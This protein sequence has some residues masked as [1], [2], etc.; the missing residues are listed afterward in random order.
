MERP[1]P[2]RGDTLATMFRTLLF[3]A[4]LS[5]AT[6]V[7]AQQPWPTRSV[8]LVIPNSSGA[9]PDL[10]AR[11]MAE[12]MARN[13]GQPWL[14]DNRPG[15]EEL[16]AAEAV[17]S[18]PPDGYTLALVSQSFVAVN[19][20]TLKSMPMDPARAF[21]AVAV[22]IDTTPIALGVSAALPARN[23]AELMA[24]A[25]AQPGK[26]SYG[27]TVP[28]LAMTGEWL[29]HRAG[30]EWTQIMYKSNAQQVGDTITGTVPVVFS[31]LVGLAPFAKA[32]KLRILAVTSPNR[33]EGF[34]DVPSVMET[35]PDVNVGGGLVLLA[36]AGTRADIVQRLNRETDT[37]VRS[38]GFAKRVAEFGW[39]NRGGARTPQETVEYIRVQRERWAKVVKDMGYQPK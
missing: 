21:V 9:A 10:V 39:A 24:L 5:A 23:L 38:A 18:S 8:R 13:L 14:V 19:P 6:S 27:V 29:G 7:F 32:G 15:G 11:V 36:P 25:K 12:Q 31:T 22:V 37:V 20:N 3:A 4:A 34:E 33:I 16:I 26:L 17:A 30:I 1:A 28:I 35:Y 2:L